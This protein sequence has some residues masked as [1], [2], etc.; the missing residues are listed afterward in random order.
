MLSLYTRLVGYWVD[1]MM[2]NSTVEIMLA[3]IKACQMIK[4]LGGDIYTIG[5]VFF[6]FHPYTGRKRTSVNVCKE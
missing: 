3:V 4:S 1:I 5:I 2:L 6:I